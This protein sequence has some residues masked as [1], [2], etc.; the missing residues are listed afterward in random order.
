MSNPPWTPPDTAAFLPHRPPRTLNRGSD[1]REQLVQL[2]SWCNYETAWPERLLDRNAISSSK[3]QNRSRIIARKRLVCTS[4][5]RDVKIQSQIEIHCSIKQSACS[6][7]KNHHRNFRKLY[8]PEIWREATGK[9]APAFRFTK[10]APVLCVIRAG[11]KTNGG[12]F[13][14]AVW[15]PQVL[16]PTQQ[17]SFHDMKV[18]KRMKQW[19]LY[20]YILMKPQMRNWAW[21]P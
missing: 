16:S 21:T 14:P 17:N 9:C 13:Y 8:S 12:A 4:H 7:G 2:Q 20:L 18:L 3:T 11:E 6:E 15:K 10:R 5:L 1:P 19:S